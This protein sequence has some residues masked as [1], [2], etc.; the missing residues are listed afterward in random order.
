MVKKTAVILVV[1]LISS[2]SQ[3]VISENR[4][5]I[6]FTSTKGTSYD[7]TI[8]SISGSISHLCFQVKILDSSFPAHSIFSA[9]FT[10]GGDRIETLRTG[11]PYIEVT[12]F[13]PTELL[14]GTYPSDIFS[15]SSKN[16]SL[17][18][19]REL[20]R[21][22][23]YESANIYASP[24][25][26]RKVTKDAWVLGATG[27]INTINY[28]DVFTRVM[29]KGPMLANE[30]AVLTP[31]IMHSISLLSDSS[32]PQKGLL[33][34]YST[35]LL[36]NDIVS[37]IQIV[38]L[39]RSAL[40]EEKSLAFR[41]NNQSAVSVY[42][43]GE[44]RSDIKS[45]VQS[46]ALVF[47]I[48]DK[49]YDYSTFFKFARTKI[50]GTGR[51]LIITKNSGM[52][53]TASSS[54]DFTKFADGLVSHLSLNNF[55][56]T[57]NLN[58]IKFGV[59]LAGIEEGLYPWIYPSSAFIKRELYASLG[60][61][62]RLETESIY[63]NLNL[64]PIVKKL[65]QAYKTTFRETTEDGEISGEMFINLKGLGVGGAFYLPIPQGS[66]SNLSLDSV[67]GRMWVSLSFPF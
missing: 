4:I 37:I 61:F 28:D 59:T 60:T 11:K 23:V 44:R 5:S 24:M 45:K 7:K 32:F 19:R 39:S 31:D 53:F 16:D 62:I 20:L 17:A 51:I 21:N 10:I 38:F 27:G 34:F 65:F 64:V 6:S 25:W 41:T 50:F 57:L 18:V 30:L 22:I 52:S 55:S 2:H 48:S 58:F 47:G 49:G 42:Y 36:V 15:L 40:S 3:A 12:F 56:A 9:G 43:T 46:T 67:N 66:M 63:A 14:K 8:P 1:L 13:S 26:F 35:P 33:C 29:S 54:Y